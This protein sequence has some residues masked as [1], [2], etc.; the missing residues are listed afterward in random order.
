MLAATGYMHHVVGLNER[1]RFLRYNAG[2]FFAPHYDASFKRGTE[3]GNR[4]GE[5]SLLTM[6]L[7]LNEGF[8]GGTTSFV[9]ED[10]EQIT[11]DVTPRTGMVL[12]FDHDIYH[13]G[14]LLQSDVKYW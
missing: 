9:D 13:C 7:Y 5:C 8:G 14:G 2:D 11:V 1:L 6:M 10:N 3:A 12:I 4:C